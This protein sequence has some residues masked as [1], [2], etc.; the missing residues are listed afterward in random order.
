[1]LTMKCVNHV[2]PLLHCSFKRRRMFEWTE[3]SSVQ[4]ITF[5]KVY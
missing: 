5:D 4:F 3:K 2:N 1:M